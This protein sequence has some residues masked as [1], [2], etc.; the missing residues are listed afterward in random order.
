MNYNNH[1]TLTNY[2]L[3][4]VLK[5][6]IR[7]RLLMLLKF[8]NQL[9]IKYK[10]QS[11]PS[12]KKIVSTPLNLLKMCKHFKK[13]Y[14]RLFTPKICNFRCSK[15][16][17]HVVKRLYGSREQNPLVVY[18]NLLYG[19]DFLA[20]SIRLLSLSHIFSSTYLPL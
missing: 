20:R 11:P 4:F 10:K 1:K 13:I 12:R 15:Q 16:Y 2:N 7:T 17:P 5:K 19:I 14:F 18:D 3:I 8:W 9:K 6:I